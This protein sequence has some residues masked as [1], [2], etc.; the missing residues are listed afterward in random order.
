MSKGNYLSVILKNQFIVYVIKFAIIFCLLYYGTLAWIGLAAPGGK[1]VVFIEKY[2]DYVSW[3]KHSLI[4]ASA[5]ILSV[6]GIQTLKEPGFLLKFP[7]GRGVIIAMDCVGYGVYSF[8]IAF[9]AANTGS[10]GRKIKWMITGVF[11]L[12]LINVIRITLFLT[13]INKGWPM[14]LGI[15]HHTWFNIFAYLFIF[16]MIWW[17]D[18]NAKMMERDNLNV[19]T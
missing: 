13:S 8:W 14:P 17:Y 3:I 4:N 5:F 6:F 7:G 16:I 19:N 9:V 2:L 10:V 18:R 15:D 12:W 11:F 1:H